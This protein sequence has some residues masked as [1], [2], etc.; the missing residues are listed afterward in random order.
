ME[1]NKKGLGGIA[2]LPLFVFLGLYIGSGI[3]FTIKGVAGPF[4]QFSR[5]VALFVALGVVLMMNKQYKIDEKIEIFSESAGAPGVMMMGLIYLLAGGFSGAAK[6]M[7]GVESVVNLGLTFIPSHFI[8]P[9]IFLI[10][11]F[12]ATAMGTSMGTMAAMAPIAVGVAAKSNINVAITLAAVMGGAYFGDNLSILSDTTISATR[13]VGC[14]MKDKFRMNF[15][16]AVPA[17]VLTMVMYTI[18]GKAGN[19]EGD[20]T[21]HVVKVL[22]YILVL[23]G[24][25]AGGNVIL[26]LMCGIILCGIVG[27]ATGSVTFIGF[28]KAISGGMEDMMGITIVAILIAGIIG[29]IKANGGIDWLIEKITSKVKTRSGAEYGIAVLS[30]ALSASLVNNTVAIIIAAPIAKEIGSKYKI[31]KKR[32]ASLL[33]IFA[34]GMLALCPHD[35]GMLIM[36]GMGNVTPFEILKFAYYPIFLLIATLI[37]IKFGLMRTKEEKQAALEAKE[38]GETITGEH[39][40]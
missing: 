28:V 20:L 5:Y 6:S 1:K 29:S 23:V 11:C 4:N 12:I 39:V 32:L 3:I 21:F 27:L 14:D 31:A 16:I 13:G 25:I 9:G 24:A 15:L 2:F 8:V 40:K 30:A 37:T 7:G 36:T 19:I 18:M 34:C 33:D 26:V 17:A 10:S 35:G 22:P 38:H